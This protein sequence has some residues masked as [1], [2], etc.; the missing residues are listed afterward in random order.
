MLEQ[1]FSETALIY[2]AFFIM[3]CIFISLIAPSTIGKISKQWAK[4]RYPVKVLNIFFLLFFFSIFSA[5]A[6]KIF[7]WIFKSP[8]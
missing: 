7:G 8:F 3:W 6:S 1:N 2:I 4:M 5:Y